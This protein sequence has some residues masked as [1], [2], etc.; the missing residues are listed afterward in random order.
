MQALNSSIPTAS[1]RY[2]APPLIGQCA[3]CEIIKNCLERIY[4][5]SSPQKK[6]LKNSFN[7]LKDYLS[8]QQL[9]TVLIYSGTSRGKGVYHGD[10]ETTKQFFT[11]LGLSC[12]SVFAYDFTP[13]WWDS[14]TTALFIPGA[15]S[16]E[17]DA[18]LQGYI[19]T[20]RDYLERG[21]KLLAVCGGAYWAC[22]HTEYKL[23]AAATLRKE[24][25]LSLFPGIGLGPL[26]Y[27]EQ[28]NSTD[29]SFTHR[30]VKLEHRSGL[31]FPSMISGGGSFVTT[32]NAADKKN[33][34]L[35][36]S[37][38]DQKEP[39][40]NAIVRCHVG[41]GRAL[42]SF[43]HL[44]YGKKDVSVEDYSK[45][46]PHHPWQQLHDDLKGSKHIRRLAFAIQVIELLHSC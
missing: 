6:E 23:N 40:Q 27:R 25:S 15:R 4:N 43:V 41:G 33:F 44:G 36:A 31:R 22:R 35:I 20:I 32:T 11:D 2:I 42:L 9:K 7:L 3:T 14:N 28:K 38:L 39:L 24:R 8:K 21:G 12:V 29:D 37:Y 45:L 16:S 10:I 18:H 1:S 13:Q 19:P 46:F 5:I 17:L 26:F 34:Q 30:V